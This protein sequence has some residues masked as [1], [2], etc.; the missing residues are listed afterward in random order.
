MK[1]IACGYTTFVSTTYQNVDNTTKRR[2]YCVKCMFR[3]TTREK[4]EDKDQAK[5]EAWRKKKSI[6]TAKD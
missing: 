4:A 3:F 1:C 6:S 5:V 2:R